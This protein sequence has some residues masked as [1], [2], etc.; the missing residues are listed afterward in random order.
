MCPDIPVGGGGGFREVNSEGV[1]KFCIEHQ[2]QPACTEADI[3]ELEHWRTELRQ[4]RLI[5]QDPLKYEGLGYGNLSKRMSD[6][7]VLMSGSQT[8]HLEKL[9]QAEYARVIEFRV[10]Q[11]W[12]RSRGLVHPSSETMTHLAIY[13]SAPEIGFVFHAHCAEIWE[14]GNDL[15]IPRTDPLAECGTLAMFHA[16]QKLLTNYDVRHGG[17]FAIGGHT[18]GIIVWGKTADEAGEILLAVLSATANHADQVIA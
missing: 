9:T 4:R 7:T 10:A 17:I 1:I 14:A 5:G 18:D 2:N 8:G 15:N 11:N 13:G 3:G 12:I 6:G 16:A